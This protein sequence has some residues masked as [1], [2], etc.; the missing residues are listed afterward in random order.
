MIG[1]DQAKGYQ[2]ESTGHSGEDT[3][4]KGTEYEEAKKRALDSIGRT[5]STPTD[6]I[7]E[8]EIKAK[9]DYILNDKETLLEQ[10]NTS[11]TH[12]M[13]ALRTQNDKII[14]AIDKMGSTIAEELK[15]IR[16]TIK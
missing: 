4:E 12:D 13:M 3:K 6:G 14:M 16:Q 8:Q 2:D 1:E 10:K 7:T 9:A 15:K 5:E 11:L